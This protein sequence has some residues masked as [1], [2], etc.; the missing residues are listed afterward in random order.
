[1]AVGEQEAVVSGDMSAATRQSIENLWNAIR[2]TN[3]Q[4]GK[5]SRAF[6]PIPERRGAAM[7][8]VYE[9]VGIAVAATGAWLVYPPAAWLL[10]GAWM[11]GDVVSKRNR[12]KK[13][14]PNAR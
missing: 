4:V 9:L 13:E 14:K 8:I 2:Q 1:V 11:L 6:G 5:L 12:S 7:E 3:E 10:V